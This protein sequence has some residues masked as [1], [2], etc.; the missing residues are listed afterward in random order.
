MTTAPTSVRPP[1]SF[2]VSAATSKSA[3]CTRT[4]TMSASGHRGEEGDFLRRA[5]RRR[6]LDVDAV[7]R[8]PHHLRTLKGI[9]ILGSAILQPCDEI[10]NRGHARGQLDGFLRAADL[11]PHPG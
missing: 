9:A 5:K 7:E 11:L 1:R 4:D 3:V 6:W 8:S 2:S 10:G